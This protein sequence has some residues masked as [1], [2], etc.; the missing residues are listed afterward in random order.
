MCRFGAITDAEV[1]CLAGSDVMNACLGWDGYYP[2]IPSTFGIQQ[3]ECKRCRKECKT[4]VSLNNC[5][6]CL[7]YKIV[8]SDSKE[9]IGCASKCGEGNY[10]LHKKTSNRVGTC[11]QC[12]ALCD[13]TK[14]CTGPTEYDCV[15]CDFAGIDLL[16][17]V[18]C[19]F[20]CPETHPF[21][22]ENFCHEYDVAIEA[23]NR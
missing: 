2:D 22:Y 10:E 17:N 16:T 1:Q 11:Q 23:R 20:D 15:R 19:V 21:L 5:T 14:S 13:R 4:C 9:M 12:H 18:Q 3:G 6:E 7:D 8:P